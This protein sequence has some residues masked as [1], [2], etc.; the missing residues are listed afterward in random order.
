LGLAISEFGLI[1]GGV[2]DAGIAEW[3][4]ILAGGVLC[5]HAVPAIGGKTFVRITCSLLCYPHK[6]NHQFFGAAKSW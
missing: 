2:R 3:R 6:N 1:V 4:I 5:N